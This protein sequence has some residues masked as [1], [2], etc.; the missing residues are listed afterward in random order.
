MATI[1]DIARET[2][3][4]ASTVSK[5]MNNYKG[6]SKKSKEAVYAAID[7]LDYSPNT[8][9]LVLKKSFLIGILVDDDENNIFFH[10]HYSGILEG[11]KRYVESKGY[12][13]VFVNQQ[14]GNTDAS[15]YR[16][17]KYRDVEG[18]L[19]V[20]SDLKCQAQVEEIIRSDI[21]KV[22]IEKI[23]ANVPIVISDNYSGAKK[24]MEYLYFL[25]HR[26]IA[27][28][29][30]TT[31]NEP[32]K[33]RLKAYI[34]YMNKK[35]LEKNKLVIEVED[36]SYESGIKAGCYLLEQGME[37]MP[38]AVFCICDE[39]ARGLIDALKKAY[40]NVPEDISVI[41]F[42]DILI[43]KYLNL[44]TVK[45]NRFEIGEEAARQLLSKIEDNCYKD[46]YT[47]ID[48]Q[49]IVRGTCRML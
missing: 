23:Y 8:R 5:V 41:G 21:P 49:L 42:D 35:N 33:D 45:Q 36:F 20:S 28:V 34:D 2:G 9:P 47:Q 48:T 24:A 11:F 13:I 25:K 39:I 1:Y 3:L 31:C 18:V 32:V 22:S 46:Y 14:I 4:S 37:K 40:I 7:K 29:N 30:V 15:F 38:T 26:E 12:D 44:T 43:A 27:Y 10:F 17:C 6:T 16:H 19:I